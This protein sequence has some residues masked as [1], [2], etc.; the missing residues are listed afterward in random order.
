[1]INA[2]LVPAR[3]K[4]SKIRKSCHSIAGI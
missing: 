4:E 3:G 2:P 1:V